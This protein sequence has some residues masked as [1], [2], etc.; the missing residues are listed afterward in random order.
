VLSVHI[1]RSGLLLVGAA[2]FALLAL[3]A[4]APLG[5]ARLC[6]PRLHGGL[7]VVAAVTLALAPVV[8]GLRPSVIGIIVVEAAALGWLRVTTLTRY[9]PAAPEAL[10]APAPTGGPETETVRDPD[11]GGTPA[12]RGLGILAGRS[13]RRLPDVQEKLRAGARQA[14]RHAARLHRT[15]RRP[16]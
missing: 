3:T 7:D 11:T 12:A 10:G 9:S 1:A 4:R 13:A 6:G 2:L 15:W 5:L 8:S 16:T 14:G